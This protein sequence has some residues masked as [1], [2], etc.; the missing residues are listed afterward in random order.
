MDVLAAEM[1][2]RADREASGK[3]E[4]GGDGGCEPRGQ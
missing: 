4:V 2:A 3:P 1:E